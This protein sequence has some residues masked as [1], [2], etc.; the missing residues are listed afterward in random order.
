MG[1]WVSVFSV[2]VS[3]TLCLWDVATCAE[4]VSTHGE[5]AKIHN[6]HAFYLLL[7]SATSAD[8]TA[9][10]IPHTNVPLD[11]HSCFFFWP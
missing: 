6:A 3:G 11:A 10:S 8:A 1:S 5:G 7:V 9:V 2:Y 4:K